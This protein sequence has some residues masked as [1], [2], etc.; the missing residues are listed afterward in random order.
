MSGMTLGVDYMKTADN[1]LVPNRPKLIDI[2][3][4]K[5][6]DG[7]SDKI[8]VIQL[9]LAKKEGG[10]IRSKSYIN[11]CCG[12]RCLDIC[13]SGD[14]EPTKREENNKIFEGEN[15]RAVDDRKELVDLNEMAIRASN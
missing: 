7:E 6:N 3:D 8:G 9:R 12:E 13:R 5:G 4:G 10:E 1:V 11:I 2:S 14:G 15:I